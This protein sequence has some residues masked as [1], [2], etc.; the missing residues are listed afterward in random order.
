MTW[1]Y[2]EQRRCGNRKLQA[3]VRRRAISTHAIPPVHT[4]VLLTIFQRR[5][6]DCWVYMLTH[7]GDV[8]QEAECA[9]KGHAPS[10]VFQHATLSD[11]CA[12]M[13]KADNVDVVVPLC[14]KAVRHAQVNRPRSR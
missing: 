8:Q 13:K 3:A 5:N 2:P 11:G 12:S 7:A 9:A 6:V 14:P 10:A 4:L 1:N